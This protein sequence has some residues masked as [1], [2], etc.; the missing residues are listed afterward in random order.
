MENS[1]GG[2]IGESLLW[3]VSGQGETRQGHVEA[4][5]VKNYEDEAE[6]TQIWEVEMCK[7]TVPGENQRVGIFHKEN[8]TLYSSSKR[9]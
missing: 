2:E 5:Q 7:S 6:L 8:L 3:L 1:D 9:V 4:C